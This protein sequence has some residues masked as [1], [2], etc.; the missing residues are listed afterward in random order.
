MKIL[1]VVYDN[2][3]HIHSFPIGLGYI[4]AALAQ[5]GCEVSIYSQDL[6]HY[7][8]AHLTDYLDQNHFD[9]VGV[10]VI[11]GYYQYRKLL[12]LSA[13]INRS[14]RRPFYVLGGH[15]PS[16]E[17]DFFLRKTG[18]DAIVIGEGEATTTE[19][20]RTLSHHK[21]LA[22]IPGLAF[23]DGDKTVVNKKRPLIKDLDSIPFPAYDL[24]PMEYYRLLPE[25]NTRSRDFAM[26]MISGRG[27]PFKCAFC[28]RMD[29]GFRPRSHGKIIEEIRLLQSRY[30]INYISFVDELLMSSV[31]RTTE[32]CE[33]FIKEKLD[34]RWLCNG[35]LNFARP[36][37]LRLM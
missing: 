1:L 8:D 17:P 9:V 20:V 6:H 34:I 23:K 37:L 24:F 35:R 10:G 21:P 2:D 5:E 11:S 29:E 13:A 28:Y 22:E 33:A 27:C 16:P 7:P 3:M 19:L 26:P 31:G 12:K 15:G 32:L 4:A 36:A 14:K 18:A 25:P 30:R